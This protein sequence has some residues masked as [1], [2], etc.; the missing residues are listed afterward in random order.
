MLLTSGCDGYGSCER[1]RACVSVAVRARFSRERQAPPA[2]RPRVEPVPA[3]C[4]SA[5]RSVSLPT[6]A[7]ASVSPLAVL[8]GAWRCFLAVLPC[9]SSVERSA[10]QD[11][12][13]IQQL[14]RRLPP[15]LLGCLSLLS[16]LPALPLY[17]ASQS[18]VGGGVLLIS[19]LIPWLASPFAGRELGRAEI[20]RLNWSE[21][22]VFPPQVT[23]PVFC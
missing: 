18:C 13:L 22:S 6:L 7:A 5:V 9:P 14:G 19:S 23:R 15:F 1:A 20:L 4:A 17:S 10:E 3:T 16:D 11:L 2:L 12:S 8:L 21:L